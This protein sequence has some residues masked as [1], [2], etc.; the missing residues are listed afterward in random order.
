M[1]RGAADAMRPMIGAPGR[2]LRGRLRRARLAL[3]L[4]ASL[5]GVATAFAPPLRAAEW[6]AWRGPGQDANSS[7]TGLISRWS[8]DGENLIWK[9]PLT[10]RSTPIVFDGRA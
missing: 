9:V 1:P 6:P 10:A 8:Q 4:L 7:E 2:R 5:L 3:A